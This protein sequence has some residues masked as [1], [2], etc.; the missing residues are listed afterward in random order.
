M[1]FF[2]LFII[3]I[4]SPLINSG[5]YSIL[6]SFVLLF[7]I[8][9]SS[10]F[11]RGYLNLGKFNYFRWLL[12]FY[13]I[14]NSIAFL[15]ISID[16]S[17]MAGNFR[18]CILFFMFF[19]ATS[20]YFYGNINTS[21]SQDKIYFH[22]L[23]FLSISI[24]L[25]SLLYF[26][27]N[28]FSISQEKSDI[29]N[30]F[31]ITQKKIQIDYEK[32][33]VRIV[34]STTGGALSL[35]IPYLLLKQKN[36]SLLPVFPIIIL[37]FICLFIFDFRGPF[38][39]SIIAIVLSLS[40]HLLNIK[41]FNHFGLISL[42]FPL[43][44]VLFLHN[45]NS[46]SL[47]TDLFTFNSRTIIWDSFIQNIPNDIESLF[48]GFGKYGHVTS[49]VSDSYIFV[50]GDVVDPRFMVAHNFFLQEIYDSGF[51]SYLLYLILTYRVIS[52]VYQI[53]DNVSFSL[54]SF[55]IYFNL[56]GILES[57][58]YDKLLIHLFFIMIIYYEAFYISSIKK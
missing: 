15:R 58:Q 41:I 11:K 39:L 23:I 51:L 47:D 24:I 7:T 43:M 42:F 36:V 21:N 30:I 10:L 53:G 20:S 44:M 1:F 14:I 50:S 19:Y 22:L 38:F 25:P 33:N 46:L 32:F 4:Y 5:L 26:I 52:K 40:N 16:G 56:I 27:Q 37:V 35:L 57:I 9:T 12:F 29:L 48:L 49:G 18:E 3:L 2:L 6:F 34:S 8:F 17:S 13:A 45:S 31:G 54:L 55:L 28:G